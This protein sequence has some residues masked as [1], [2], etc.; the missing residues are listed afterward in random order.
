M[1]TLILS[2]TNRRDSMTR[3]LSQFVYE[4][5]Q[6]R[7]PKG[8]FDLMD[9]VELPP[10]IFLPEVY[11]QKPKSFEPWARRFVDAD[12]IISILPEY[13]GAA[14]G[15]FKYFI[16]ML[17]FPEALYKIPC[18]FFGLSA[19]R[20]GAL[21]SVEQVQQVFMYRN[22]LVYPENLFIPAVE[23]ALTET[24]GPKDEFLQKLFQQYLDGFLEFAKACQSLRKKS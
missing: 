23:S 7:D 11:V 13:N 12:A 17:P 5:I 8:S 20:F 22:A 9:L 4:E 24:G 6:S 18:S 21:R 15:V 16:D 19:G 10:E 2:G 3:R 1:K 14:P